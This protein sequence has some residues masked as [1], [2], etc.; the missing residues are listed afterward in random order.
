MKQLLFLSCCATLLFF[1]SSCDK[2][3]DC[4]KPEGEIE[5]QIIELDEI[6]AFEIFG[7]FELVIQEGEAQE[8]EITGHPNVIEALLEDSKIKDGTWDV[9]IKKCIA[10]WKKS[11]LVINATLANNLQ[12]ISS[13]GNA[14]ISTEGVFNKIDVLALNIEGAGDI[15]LELGDSIK[16]IGTQIFGNGNVTISGKTID[17]SID[18]DGRGDINYFNLDSKNSN[19]KITGAGN[20]EVT[21]TDML[22]IKISG[23]GNLCFKGN[24]E[25]TTKVTGSGKVNDC[26]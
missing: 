5:T 11:E 16:K 22:D 26:N 13:I 6:N 20:C 24:P 10:N 18:I 9:G 1:Y 12:R 4:I 2:F 19:I 8:I 23:S 25:I 3:T 17:S 15:N 21:A 14:D 7:A